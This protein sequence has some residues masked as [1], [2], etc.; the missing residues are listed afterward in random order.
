MVVGQDTQ[1]NDMQSSKS[2]FSV[3]SQPE[4]SPVSLTD[5]GVNTNSD[6]PIMKKNT[7]MRQESVLDPKT[8]WG[9]HELTQVEQGRSINIFPGG[10][11]M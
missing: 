5:P 3:T 4:C 9:P 6:D 7:K 10:I 2:V 11:P 1:A 8:D